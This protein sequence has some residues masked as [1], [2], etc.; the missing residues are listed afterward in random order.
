MAKKL[1]EKAGLIHL[2]PAPART[3]LPEGVIGSDADSS[4]AKTAP[5]SMLQFMTAQLSLIHI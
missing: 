4:K 1:L 2:P 5:G 3:P